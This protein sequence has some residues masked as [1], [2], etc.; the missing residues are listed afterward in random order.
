M[1]AEVHCMKAN[2][3]TMPSAFMLSPS[4]FVF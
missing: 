2:R 4:A 3:Q 1:K